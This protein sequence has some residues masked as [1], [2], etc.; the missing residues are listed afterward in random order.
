MS[1]VA[2]TKTLSPAARAARESLLSLPA[3]D[4]AAVLASLPESDAA[5][6]VDVAADD[7]D[8]APP[9]PASVLRELDRDF[10]EIEAGIQR[11]TPWAEFEEELDRLLATP[12]DQL[13][14]RH[15]AAVEAGRAAAIAAGERPGR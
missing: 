12:F 9:I 6:R 15:R 7:A 5:A 10:E 14:P 1:T 11:T 2:E 8:E 4:R 13:S 3:P